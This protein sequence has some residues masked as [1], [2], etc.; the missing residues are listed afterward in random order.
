MTRLIRPALREFF[1]DNGVKVLCD[2]PCGDADWIADISDCLDLYLGFDIVEPLIIRNMRNHRAPNKLFK[3]ADIIEDVLPRADAILCRDCL[4][5]LPLEA[6]KQ[7][8]ENFKKSGSTYLIAT[9]FKDRTENPE[10]RIGGW[11]PVNL[12]LPP[13]NLPEPMKLM[14]EIDNPKS[15]FRDKSL[16]IWAI[17]DLR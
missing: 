9:T 15:R 17:A 3:F 11:R 7:A 12:T 1:V 16:G 8:I 4:V 14:P 2:A 6:G 5:H 13:Y 10:V